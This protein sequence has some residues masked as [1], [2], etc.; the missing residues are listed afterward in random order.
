MHPETITLKQKKI[1]EKLDKFPEFYLVGGTA[2]AL[3]IGHRISV[4]FD[5]FWKKDISKNILNKIR[6]IFKGSKIEIIIKHSEQ[7]SVIVDGIKIDFVKYPF[8]WLFKP[9]KYKGVNLAKISEIAVM[10]AHAMGKRE[11]LKDY[12]DLYYILKEKYLS[13][14][15]IIKLAQ[16]KYK[17]D[18]NPRLFLEQLIYPEDASPVRVRF[19]KK[20]VSAKEM[21]DFFEK[22]IRQSKLI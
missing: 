20:P 15:R 2:L 22:Q 19:L 8:L 16:R 12:I 1:F 18:F 11:T 7:L 5:M 10:K 3:Q 21:K 14:G 9:I 4:D 17:D 13:L 6:R